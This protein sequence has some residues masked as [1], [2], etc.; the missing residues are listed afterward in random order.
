MARPSTSAEAVPI[1]GLLI[2]DSGN[3]K[4]GALAS[5]VLAGYRLCVLDYDGDF[6]NSYAVN[7]LRSHK[8]AADLL[9]RVHFVSL[10]DKMKLVG[11]EMVPVAAVPDA[12]VR[13]LKLL[14]HWKDDEEDLGPTGGFDVGTVI[15]IDSL[16][17]MAEA[18]F[19]YEKMMAPSKDERMIY[20]GAQKLVRTVIELLTS[21]N[22]RCHVLVLS[23]ISYLEMENGITRGFPQAV[24]SK[25]GPEIPKTFN[26]MLEAA[27]KGG[28]R[29]IRTVPSAAV[30]NKQPIPSGVPE[31][32]PVA[33]GL[34][35]YFALYRKL[36]PVATTPATL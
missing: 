2:G 23:H 12:F 36:G 3:G 9:Q 35:T 10:R 13:G 20:Y 1:K 33:T 18:A 15:V 7:I 31:E 11:K 6:D 17:K 4:T 34:A 22:I 29:V 24:G 8:D 25:A 26:I 14:D 16:S 32:L 30:A 5:L 28:N 21:S 27:R 19:L